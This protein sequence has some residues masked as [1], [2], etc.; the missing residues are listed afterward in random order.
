MTFLLVALLGASMM[1]FLVAGCGGGGDPSPNELAQPPVP[2]ASLS[3]T[4]DLLSAVGGTPGPVVLQAPG[5]IGSRQAG[6]GAL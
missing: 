4:P 1:G 6:P 5:G 2:P 3:P